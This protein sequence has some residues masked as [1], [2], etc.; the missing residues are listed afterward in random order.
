MTI[1]KRIVVLGSSSVYGTGDPTGGFVAK[2]RTWS[3]AKN[4]QN[5]VYNLG[6]WGDTTENMIARLKT[7][8]Q[9]RRPQLTILYPGLNDI[10]RVGSSSA[11]NHLSIRSYET[12]ITEMLTT[13]S[14]HSQVL[15]MSAIPFDEKRT[16]PYAQSD[17]Y[18]LI[19]D[20]QHYMQV[21]ENTCVRTKVQFLNV[22]KRWASEKDF[23]YLAPDGLHPSV[24]GHERLFSEVRDYLSATYP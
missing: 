14:A 20:A 13:T 17:W 5:L 9:P 7:E 21:L 1:P 10:R 22:F 18:Y 8:L 19:E 24:I 11:D 15:V 12:L 3:E 4:S 16:T 23:A 6:V 2:L